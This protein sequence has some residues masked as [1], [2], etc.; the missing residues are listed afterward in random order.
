MAI[1]TL[2]VGGVRQPHWHP[3]AWELNYV[4]SGRCTRCRSFATDVRVHSGK[5][6]WT[7]VGTNGNHESF[8][9]NAGDLV[10]I[11]RGLFHYFANGDS[12]EELKV[13]I[14]FNSSQVVEDD[15]IG[16]VPA[17]NRMPLSILA[18][19]FDMPEEYFKAMRRNMT[20]TNIILRKA[21]K[22]NN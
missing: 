21:A 5:A 3:F 19:S 4:V 17:F 9:A 18:A 15:D 11:P 22:G 1:L 12:E 8:V 7:I 16:I 13:L 20:Q 6:T 10:F 2:K 14:V